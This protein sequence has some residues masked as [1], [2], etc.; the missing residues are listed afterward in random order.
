MK[1]KP[2]WEHL[3]EELHVLI[4][5]E[6]SKNRATVKLRR[7]FDEVKKLLVPVVSSR[8]TIRLLL[9]LQ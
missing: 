1:G 6:D 3:N 7:A 2:K 4:T 9:L 8:E 5:V